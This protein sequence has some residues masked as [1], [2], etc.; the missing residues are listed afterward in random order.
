MTGSGGEDFFPL[1][2]VEDTDLTEAELSD[3]PSLDADLDLDLDLFTPAE[4]DL[5]F[6]L[7]PLFLGD[8]DLLLLGFG[9]RC[10]RNK[11]RDLERLPDLGGVRFLLAGDRERLLT[12]DLD[13]DR[14][15]E[16]GVLDLVRLRGL[17]DLERRFRLSTTTERD[18]VRLLL[19]TDRDRERRDL[20]SGDLHR[21]DKDRLL[22]RL[23]PARRAGD[24]DLE[25]AACLLDLEWERRGLVT[26][27]DSERLPTAPPRLGERVLER[28]VPRE[29]DSDLRRLLG[30]RDREG[31]LRPPRLG[32][33]D[34]FLLGEREPLRL[35]GETDKELFRL[36]DFDFLGDFDNFFLGVMDREV[37]RDRRLVFFSDL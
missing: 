34:I 18:R 30:D 27:R 32:D 24:R 7:L 23:V 6:D 4:T 11:E 36:G 12:G 9:D 35:F 14:R 17:L 2:G 22:E 21:L 25:R 29:R 13:L 8:L 28:L 1:T 20:G 16:G 19:R 31:D 26:E 3:R 5:D 15:R 10:L 37:D 33:R